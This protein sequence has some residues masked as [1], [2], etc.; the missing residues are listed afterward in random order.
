[1]PVGWIKTLTYDNQNRPTGAS[2]NTTSGGTVGTTFTYDAASRVTSIVRG[3]TT[4]AFGYDDANRKIW[5]D[6]T[7]SGV[8]H[9]AGQHGGECRW[10]PRRISLS[11]GCITSPTI[12]P[13][14]GNSPM[15]TNTA[16]VQWFEYT[17]DLNGN[18]KKRQNKYQGLDSTKLRLR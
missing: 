1:M 6:Q 11:R 9:P 15:I 4:V 2:W 10:R 5:E 14:A 12:I 18:L 3:S 17:Y 16:G 8:S 13:G 7:L